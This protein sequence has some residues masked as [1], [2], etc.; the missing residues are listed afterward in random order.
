MCCARFLGFYELTLSRYHISTFHLELKGKASKIE[1]ESKISCDGF[2]WIKGNV[3]EHSLGFS[4]GQHKSGYFGVHIMQLI[5]Y[6]HNI[7]INNVSTN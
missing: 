7:I 2:S 1:N 5:P 3:K 4:S 6:R